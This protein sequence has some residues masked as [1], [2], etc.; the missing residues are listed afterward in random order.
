MKIWT[1][2]TGPGHSLL[3]SIHVHST[4]KLS[5]FAYYIIKNTDCKYSFNKNKSLKYFWK[6]EWIKVSI[7]SK[8]FYI[9]IKSFS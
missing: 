7:S 1:D 5:K 3:L 6:T 9:K 8:P 4:L 2:V